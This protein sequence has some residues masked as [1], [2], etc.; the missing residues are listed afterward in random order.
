MRIIARSTLRD[1]WG[2]HPDAETPLKVWFA[3]VKKAN[4]KNFNELKAQ[5]G[6]ASVVGND[7]VVFNIKGNEYRLI[8]AIDYQKQILWIRFVGTHK[9]YDKIDAKTI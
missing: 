9:A 8:A 2:K 5:F 1:Y 4:W 6:N 3:Q 7:R